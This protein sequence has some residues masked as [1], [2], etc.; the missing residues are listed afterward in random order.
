MSKHMPL[1]VRV[2]IER[3]N[4]S[5]WR[6]EDLCIKCGMCKRVCENDLAVHGRY[7]LAKTGDRAVCIYCGQCAN[8]CPPSSI[9]EVGEWEQVRAAIADPD[10]VV[11]V[12]T[13]P[14]VRVSAGE[15]FGEEPGTFVQGK[16]ISLLRALGFDY[17]L[18]TNFAADLTIMEEANELVERIQEGGKLPQFTS[19]CPAWVRYVETFY[20]EL[21]GNLSSA[22]SPIGMQGPTIKTYFAQREGIDPKRIVNVALTPCTAKKFEIHREEMA[23]AGKHMGID[24]M[25]DM[26]HV[27][28]VRE[29]GEWGHAAGIDWESLSDD[30]AYDDLMG[31]ASGAGVIFGNTGGVMEAALRTAHHMLIGEDAPANLLEL[32]SVRGYE[33]VRRATVELGGTSL[34]VAVIYGTTNARAFIEGER[35]SGGTGL[36]AF[37]F[38]EVMACP[39]GCIGG[40]GQPKR[41]G[42]AADKARR[43]RI[44]GL[45]ERD[46]ELPRRCSYE[47]PQIQELYRSFYGDP[48]SALAEEMLHTVYTDNSAELGA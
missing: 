12:S 46:R 6:D 35:A 31:Q 20:S 39:G 22:K 5:I 10:A 8:V 41:L 16:L 28:T 9:R 30:G 17:V 43:A 37:Q 14:A 29:L 38:V 15:L 7:D 32:E 34:E 44:A 1:D 4:P 47:N 33:G 40:G 23:D 25:R 26:D 13:S 42:P 45:Y 48:G 36:S 18:D 24:G 11:V 3:N 2:A 27:I 19:C 21:R